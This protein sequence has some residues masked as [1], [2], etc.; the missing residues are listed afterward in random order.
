MSLT[1]WL[2]NGWLVRHSTTRQEI[3]RL[4]AVARRDLDVASGTGNGDWKFGVAYNA[5]L[6]LC[7]VLLYAAGYRA[8][9]ELQS[10]AIAWLEANHPALV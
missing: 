4:L 1:Q 2:D 5:A 6:K 9:S 8:V 3:S 7:T 10:D